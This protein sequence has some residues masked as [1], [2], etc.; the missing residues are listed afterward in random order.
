MCIPKSS[1]WSEETAMR[2]HHAILL[3][4]LTGAILVTLSVGFALLR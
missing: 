3:S 4:L 1:N 2:R